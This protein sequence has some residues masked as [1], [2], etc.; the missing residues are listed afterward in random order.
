MSGSF[1][2]DFICNCVIL[3]GLSGDGFPMSGFQAAQKLLPAKGKGCV[4]DTDLARIH[5]AGLVIGKPADLQALREA[6]E[7]YDRAQR[8][9]ASLPHALSPEAKQWAVWGEQGTSSQLIFATLTGWMG[10]IRGERR[11]SAPY[12]HDAGD[13]RRCLLVVEQIPGFRERLPELSTL[14][15]EW[16]RLVTSWS[17][18]E[19]AFDQQ[20]PG[21]REGKFTEGNTLSDMVRQV[22]G[23]DQVATDEPVTPP[24]P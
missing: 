15:P 6:P 4:I 3:R 18:L 2:I 1:Q 5:E 22:T 13:F 11:G 24:V 12:P 19:A 21:W 20:A 8:L 23:E 14:S 17:D 7:T 10:L 9:A 16:E